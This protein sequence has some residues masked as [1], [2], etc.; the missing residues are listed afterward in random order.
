MIGYLVMLVQELMIVAVA[1][2]IFLMVAAFVR[3]TF[4][5]SSIWKVFAFFF[6][7]STVTC[8]YK[9]SGLRSGPSLKAGLNA[10]I[11]VA[12]FSLTLGVPLGMS[13]LVL[14]RLG[15]RQPPR[16]LGIQMSAAWLAG[17]GAGAL[18]VITYFIFNLGGPFIRSAVI[19][20]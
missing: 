4:G 1:G 9:L 5:S 16:S 17:L 18:I 13:G 11:T 7:V 6:V 15:D 3:P 2:L 12:Y 10:F 20:R 8:V 14:Q 19:P